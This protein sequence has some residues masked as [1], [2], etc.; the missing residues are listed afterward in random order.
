[1]K[2]LRTIAAVLVAAVLVLGP[3]IAFAAATVTVTTN[4]STYAG[5]NPI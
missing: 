4:A 3:T 1:M 5:T 2:T